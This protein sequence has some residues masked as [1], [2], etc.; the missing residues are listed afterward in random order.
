MSFY[1]DFID[2]VADNT[3]IFEEIGHQLFATPEY[4][5]HAAEWSV[6][7]TVTDFMKQAV[8]IRL[9]GEQSAIFLDTP[10]D[11]Q[12]D[13]IQWLRLPYGV[14]YIQPDTPFRFTGYAPKTEVELR[15]WAQNH[16]DAMTEE[17]RR[18]LEHLREQ[19]EPNIH[20]IL[21]FEATKYLDTSNKAL[22]LPHE[23]AAAERYDMLQTIEGI[24]YTTVKRLFHVVF[25]MPLQDFPLNIHSFTIGVL[26]DNTIWCAKRTSTEAVLTKAQQW[27]IHLINFLS[28]PSVKLVP[29]QPDA[30]LQKARARRGKPPLPGWYEIS[31]RQVI[32]DYT[33]DKKSLQLWHHSF[34]YDVRGHFRRYTE[35]RLAG[36]CVWVSSHQRGLANQ[37][38]RPKGYKQEGL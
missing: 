27:V 37:L 23:K 11:P 30:A 31:L 16:R 17:E 29:N 21:M 36:R 26:K 35:G 15:T 1:T 33:K 12:Q 4:R 6:F 18:R 3:R 13:F 2:Q 8:I 20:G 14:I 34:R 25:L 38:Y 24:D 28:S 19:P 9:R 5:I 10:F 22:W 32:K 7:S